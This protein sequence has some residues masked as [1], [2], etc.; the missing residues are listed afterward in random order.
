MD[1]HRMQALLS[2]D[3]VQSDWCAGVQ[4]YDPFFAHP[5]PGAA[6]CR[7]IGWGW[8]RLRPRVTLGARI[9]CKRTFGRLWLSVQSRIKM[10]CASLRH[11]HHPWIDNK[12]L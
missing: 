6:S 12:R 5:P 2:T 4:E 9:R 11:L 3:Y 8:A 10:R 7:M 1:V